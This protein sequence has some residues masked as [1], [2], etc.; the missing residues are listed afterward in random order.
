M[1]EHFL[2]NGLSGKRELEGE[3][4][5]SGAKNAVLP[6]MAASLLFRDALVLTNVPEIE[7]VSR[8]SEL[9]SGMGASV[10]RRSDRVSITT[11]AVTEPELTEEI[12]KRLRASIIFIGPMLA[13]FRS[14]TFPHP[15]GCVLGAR[16]IDLFVEGLEKMG[17]VFT[18]EGKRYRVRAPKGLHGAEFFFRVPSVTGTETIMLAASIATGTTVIRNSAM[19]PE[20]GWLAEILNA[21]GAKITGAGTPTIT[22]R[23]T[24]GKLLRAKEKRFPVVPDRIEAGSFLIL[25]ALAGK[26]LSIANIEPK[27]LESLIALLDYSGLPLSIGKR[28]ITVRAP[29]AGT[30]L[31][32]VDLKTHEYPGFATDLQ[33]P[34]VVYL[35]QVAG[36]SLVFETIFEGRLNYT[37]SL[38]RMGASITMMDPHRVLVKGPTPLSGKT[39]ESPDIR[40][41]LAYVLAAA[42]ARGTSRIHNVYYIDRGYAH[43]EERLRAVGLDILRVTEA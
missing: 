32:S 31:R 14:A 39:L 9:L 25:G 43:V 6:G 20:I 38:V 7:D 10:L 41:G 2:I 12:S 13:R 24:G 18:Q 35:T 3:I 30:T 11:D 40:A 16:P 17:A 15:G 27:H 19:E 22:V 36:E 28:S 34:M 33:S 42:V 37:E 8:M 4:V 23:G 26:E 29:K 5:V 1:S 21:S